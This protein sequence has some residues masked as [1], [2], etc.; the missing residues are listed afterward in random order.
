MLFATYIQTGSPVVR[1]YIVIPDTA[2]LSAE[3]TVSVL[4]ITVWALMES[5][6]ME[7]KLATLFFIFI[8]K[9]SRYD[10]SPAPISFD[11]VTCTVLVASE[12]AGV[13][14]APVVVD[15]VAVKESIFASRSAIFV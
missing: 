2:K 14:V 1:S 15:I 12:F 7:A 6:I 10:R 4:T 9:L 11:H 5:A 13:P 3:P 8:P